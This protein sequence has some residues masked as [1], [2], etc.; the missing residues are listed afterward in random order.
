M[1]VGDIRQGCYRHMHIVDGLQLKCLLVTVGRARL[2]MELV[3]N[4]RR[5]L[6]RICCQRIHKP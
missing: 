3:T 2:A 5:A 6:F 4:L 1:R